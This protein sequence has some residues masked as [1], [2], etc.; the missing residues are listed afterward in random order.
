M[1]RERA[2]AGLAAAALLAGCH[3]TPLPQAASADAAT[4]L[5]GLKMILD[6]L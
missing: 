3:R 2:L 1:W 6:R 5:Q 4:A